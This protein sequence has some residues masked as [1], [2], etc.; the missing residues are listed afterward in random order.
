M[1]ARRGRIHA[2]G[3]FQIS[4][5][6]ALTCA[7]VATA[8][9]SPAILLRLFAGRGLRFGFTVAAD[10]TQRRTGSRCGRTAA[11]AADGWTRHT[12]LL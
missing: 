6:G 2:L 10:M 4:T 5:A 9:T 12:H 1:R 3:I 8:R 7:D 11:A